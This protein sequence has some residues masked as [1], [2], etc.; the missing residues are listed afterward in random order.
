[1]AAPVS[2]VE[3]HC[4]ETNNE[5]SVAGLPTNAQPDP[6][7]EL[8]FCNLEVAAAFQVLN[9]DIEGKR[10]ADAWFDQ[11][12]EQLLDPCWASSHRVECLIA[13]TA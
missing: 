2:K 3:F 4:P 5:F 6:K 12:A 11:A 8:Q 13:V 10:P 1:V 7:Q 9:R